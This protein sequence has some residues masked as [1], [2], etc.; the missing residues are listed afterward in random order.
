MQQWLEERADRSHVRGFSQ[1]WWCTQRGKHSVFSGNTACFREQ[2]QECVMYLILLQKC[3]DHEHARRDGKRRSITQA[4]LIA[5][6]LEWDDHCP[7]PRPYCVVNRLIS[8]VKRGEN[9]ENAA[10]LISFDI[11]VLLMHLR[12]G[13]TRSEFCNSIYRQFWKKNIIMGLALDDR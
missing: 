3:L 4:R 5:V 2:K 1:T 12:S 10:K 8:S 9:G 11:S 13:T 6:T 7:Q